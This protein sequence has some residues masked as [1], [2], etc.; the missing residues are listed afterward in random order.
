MITGIYLKNFKCFKE[1][2]LPFSPLTLLTGF[3]AG[4]KSSTFQG[5][6]LLAQS[7]RSDRRTPI[8]SLNSELVRLGTPGEIIYNKATENE[9]II[10]ME[11]DDIHL[12]FFVTE[13]SNQNALHG[14]GLR[15][16][17]ILAVNHG[18]TVEDITPE[19]DHRSFL[20]AISHPDVMTLINSLSDLVYISAIR[21]GTNDVF[22]AP[23]RPQSVYGDVG[24]QGEYAPWW[25]Y[26]QMDEPV[27]KERCHPSEEARTLR[28]QFNAWAGELFP[29]AQG[30]VQPIEK[31][32]LLR[33]ELRISEVEDWRR[34]AN[35]GYGLTYAFPVLV[36]GLLA[37]PGQI[38]IIDSPEAHLHP[39]GQSRIGHFLAHMAA[40][41][42]HV[43]VETHSDHVL[44]GVRLALQKK[45]I[46][47]EKVA[48]HFFN[49]PGA[50]VF[51]A[52]APIISPA[53]DGNGNLSEWPEG[54]FDQSEKD[55]A[56]LAGWE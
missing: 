7:M 14:N 15:I 33:L 39:Q 43:I 11:T 46:P 27:D 36:A 52:Q 47:P 34:P 56:S 40:S 20:S 35:I 19:N 23:D 18:D 49:C 51:N 42:V 29:G 53:V 10:G 31:T 22:P 41:G 21:G 9:I 48:I 6:L 4:G 54:F 45:T 25:F 55:M 26:H 30:N 50:N 24:V 3:N 32:G 28:R 16:S 17:R 2:K 5:L 38:V 37:R 44:N 1:V 8:L 13:D 12:K